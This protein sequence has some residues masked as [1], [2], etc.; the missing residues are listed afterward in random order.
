MLTLLAPFVARKKGLSGTLAERVQSLLAEQDRSVTWL[1]DQI[2][3]HRTA[4][5]RIV[6]GKATDVHL[7]TLQAI[8]RALGVSIGELVEDLPDA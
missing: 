4:T 3:L 2:G 6:N 1:A 7:S 5:S 8:A